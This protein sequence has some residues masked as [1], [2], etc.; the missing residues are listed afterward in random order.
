MKKHYLSGVMQIR[1][2]RHKRRLIIK[3]T[4]VVL[5]G[6]PP[7]THN[8]I[9]DVILMSAVFISFGACLYAYVRHRRTQESMNTMIKELE[10]LQK[11]EGDLVSVTGKIKAMEN[12][13]QDKKK[14]DRGT[15]SS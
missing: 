8:L 5:F 14:V 3:A 11:A 4:D 15:L 2:L 6:P 9:K 10:A 1:D 7:R 13:L 12:E